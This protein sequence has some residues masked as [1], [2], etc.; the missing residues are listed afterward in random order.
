MRHAKFLGPLRK[1]RGCFTARSLAFRSFGGKSYRPF[2]TLQ[3]PFLS[4]ILQHSKLRSILPRTIQK[5]LLGAHWNG[6]RRS[7]QKIG[8]QQQWFCTQQ[9]TCNQTSLSHF[10]KPL[11]SRMAVLYIGRH[12]GRAAC[13]CALRRRLPGATVLTA[14]GACAIGKAATSTARSL[15]LTFSNRSQDVHDDDDDECDL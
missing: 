4:W 12:K 7:A 1:Y 14:V 5:I 8:P 11:G 6:R 3:S 9:E 13:C 15:S 10:L 2:R